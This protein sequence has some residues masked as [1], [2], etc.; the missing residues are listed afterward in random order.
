LPR[1]CE[2]PGNAFDKAI[3][4][5]L[6]ANESKETILKKLNA[7]CESLEKEKEEKRVKKTARQ[8]LTARES[9]REGINR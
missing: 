7:V 4:Q 8:V 5:M 1:N 6:M 9:S 3:K 2:P